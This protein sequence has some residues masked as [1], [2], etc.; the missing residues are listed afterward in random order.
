MNEQRQIRC[1]IA[2]DHPPILAA[3]SDYL[4]SKEIDVVATATDGATA[5]EVIESYRP[6]VALLDVKMPKGGGIEI[7]RALERLAP[8]VGLIIYT[9][10]GEPEVLSEALD[11]GVRGFVVKDSPLPDLLRAVETVA[12]GGIYVDP[13]LAGAVALGTQ[14]TVVLTKREREVLRLL[15]D[16]LTNEAIGKELFISPETVRT[17][18]SKAITKLGADSRTH[19]VA[20]AL[21]EALIS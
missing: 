2:D 19:A 13:V 1:V 16:G 17:H 8:T 15:A 10:Q 4:R 9:G 11:V 7:A 18:V 6:D 3:V 14:R 21:R 20:T 12:A 5:R